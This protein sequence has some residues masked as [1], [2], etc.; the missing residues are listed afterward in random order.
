VVPPVPCARV[1]GV[2]FPITGD[3]DADRLLA[4]DPLALMIGMLLDQQ[5]PM[6]W[7][8]ASPAKLRRR[9][10]GH[11]DAT[12]IAAMDPEAVAAV[13]S[14]KPALHRFPGSM[15]KRT[16][17]L[18]QHLVDHYGGDAAQVWE[19]AVD[20][21]DLSARVEALPGFGKEKSRI[22][23]ALLA[24]RFGRAPDGW[25]AFAGPFAD[26]QPRSV[27]DISSEEAVLDVRAWKKAQK[28]KGK[29]NAD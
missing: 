21:A 12:E 4:E 1:V 16:H 8:F 10:G 25:E 7:A 17:A 14:E 22:F 11:L 29:T 23:I 24:K 15:G 18:C 26:A 13:F 20:A 5:V 6:E 9:L 28:A 3:E 2:P 27:A 19:G